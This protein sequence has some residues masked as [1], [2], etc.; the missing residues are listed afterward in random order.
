LRGEILLE[1]GQLHQAQLA[2]TEA[3]A[4]LAL[5]PPARR[6]TPAMIVLAQRIELGLHKIMVP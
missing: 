2:F 4:A 1:Q 6:S 5:V 3:Q